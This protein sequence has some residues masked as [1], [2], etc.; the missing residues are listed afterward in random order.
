MEDA[1]NLKGRNF[2]DI[3]RLYTGGNPVPA[4]SGR[5]IKGQEEKKGFLRIP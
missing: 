1:M 2:F 3:E 4:G 5:R